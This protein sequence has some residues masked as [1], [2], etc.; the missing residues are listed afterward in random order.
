MQ[1][2]LSEDNQNR[3]Y[4][5]EVISKNSQ[6]IVWKIKVDGKDESNENIRRISI[7]KFYEIVTGEKE[8][9][10]Q[11]VETIPIV[12]DDILKDDPSKITKNNVYSEL[13]EK[14][15]NIIK[16]LHFIIFWK[17]WRFQKIKI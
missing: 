6:N 15:E 8:S 5:V 13:L 1:D 16:S 10:K 9:F 3:C 12:M 14:D 17:I 4:L 2:K 11:L 7:D